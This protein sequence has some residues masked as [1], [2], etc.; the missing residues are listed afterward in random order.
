MRPQQILT[1]GRVALTNIYKYLLVVLIYEINDL[2][3]LQDGLH[4]SGHAEGKIRT[5]DPPRGRPS[6]PHGTKL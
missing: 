3:E 2:T 6:T 5:V 1:T 4:Y